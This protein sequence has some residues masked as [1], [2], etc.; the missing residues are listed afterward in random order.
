[1]WRKAGTAFQMVLGKQTLAMNSLSGC[2]SLICLGIEIVAHC[3]Y[4]FK[5][6][7]SENFLTYLLLWIQNSEQMFNVAISLIYFYS[8]VL[9]GIILPVLCI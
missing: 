6:C 1:M 8:H 3:D 9:A 4:L 2:L 7:A 5:L